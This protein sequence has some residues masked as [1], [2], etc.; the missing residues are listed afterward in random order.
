MDKGVA[1]QPLDYLSVVLQLAF[2]VLF[3]VTLARFL[4]RPS[5]LDFAVVAVFGST[6]ALFGYSLINGLRPGLLEPLRPL[7]I[8]CLLIQPVLVFWMVSLIQRVPRWLLPLTIAC[9]VISE[10]GI[11][12]LPPRTAPLS[13]FIA[14]YFIAGEGGAGLL[15][16][17]GSQ[18]RYGLARIRL[19]LAGLGSILFGASIFISAI[20]SA[21]AGSGTTDPTVTLVSRVGAIL[22]ALA[23]LAAFAPPRGIRSIAQRAIAFD[24]ARDLVSSPSG[25]EPV[26]LWRS[27][28]IAARE[29]LAARF[30][31]IKDSAGAAVATTDAADGP[32]T[33]GNAAPSPRRRRHGPG[34][35][36]PRAGERSRCSA[37]DRLD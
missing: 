7:I 25:T 3:L 14:V 24:L 31:E 12:F 4:R 1:Q 28:A 22:A 21:A 26:V 27:L 37:P 36:R 29:I 15:L 32:A 33:D 35:G 18:R 13:I 34:A 23:F 20:G 17:R 10:I 5:R 11:T 6:A 30:V 19:A 2:Y 8:G 16:I 9:F